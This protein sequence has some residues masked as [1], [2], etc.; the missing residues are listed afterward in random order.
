MGLTGGKPPHLHRGG[1]QCTWTCAHT[2]SQGRC[3]LTVGFGLLGPWGP[4]TLVLPPLRP[5]GYPAGRSLE[6][7]IGILHHDCTGMPQDEAR[8]PALGCGA[9]VSGGSEHQKHVLLIAGQNLNDLSLVDVDLILLHCRVIVCHQH[10]GDVAT[11]A[12]FTLQRERRRENRQ[13]GTEMRS[14]GTDAPASAPCR[15]AADQRPPDR[16]RGALHAASTL[17]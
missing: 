12:T 7:P 5:P 13:R 3:L 16:H 9:L 1:P 6:G 17:S 10:G 11:A 4:F 8:N 15:G 14:G 2:D